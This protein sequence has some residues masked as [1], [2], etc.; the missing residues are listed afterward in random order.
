ERA[1]AT[2][3]ETVG[4]GDTPLSDIRPA[5]MIGV[6]TIWVNRRGEPVP[7]LEDQIANHEVKDLMQAVQIIDGY[8]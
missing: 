4:I 3:Q 2:P 8:V 7:K 6:T 5:K 1:S